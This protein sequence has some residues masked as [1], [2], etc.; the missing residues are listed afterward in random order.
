MINKK[1]ISLRIT[2]Y[3]QETA[4][5]II[6]DILIATIISIIFILTNFPLIATIAVVV[7]YFAIAL[8]LH[9]R[10]TIQA[11][12]DK[13]KCDY[14]TESVSINK[15]SEEYS[16]MGDRLGH[17]NIRL[18]YPKEMHVCRYKIYV[19]DSNGEK[20]KL[21]SVMSSKRSLQFAVLDKHQVERLNVTYLKRSKIL[22]WVDL[23]DD[24]DKITN[25]KKKDQIKKALHTINMSI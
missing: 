15:F 6:L 25:R 16:F 20:N 17:S 19:T 18:F 13:K 14:I 12:V 9:Y 21:R 7:G 8:F 10:V 5:Q 11:L 22:I 23:V 4:I 24:I 2:P 1:T 3:L